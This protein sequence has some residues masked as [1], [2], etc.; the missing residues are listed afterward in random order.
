MEGDCSVQGRRD[1][2]GYECRV[3][4]DQRYGV[5]REVEVGDVVFELLGVVYQEGVVTAGGFSVVTGREILLHG[6]RR[7]LF[8]EGHVIH[9]ATTQVDTDHE[10][11]GGGQHQQGEKE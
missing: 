6:A 8:Q 2:L 7:C 5:C 10:A 9:L 11:G 3:L 4:N 1:D